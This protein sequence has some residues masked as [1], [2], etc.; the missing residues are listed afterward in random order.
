MATTSLQEMKSGR[1]V[2]QCVVLATLENPEMAWEESLAE[3]EELADTAGARVVDVVSQRREQPDPRTYLGKGKTEE[4]KRVVEAGEATLVIFDGELS[5][6]QQRNLEKVLD[7]QVL[8]RTGL[9]LDIFAQRANTAEGKLQV[10][11][12]QLEYLLPRLTNMWSHLSRIRGG[13]GLRGPG[14][15]Q[16]E[17]DRRRVRER[18]GVLKHKVEDLRQWR[19]AQ[20]SQRAQAQIPLISLV[21]YTNAGKSTLLNALSQADIFVEDKL[22][23]T[24]DPTTR[25]VHFPNG[26]RALVSDTVGFIRNLPTQLVN[27]FRATLE[28]VLSAEILV[29]VVDASN[30]AWVEQE[31]TVN[32]VLTELGAADKPTVIAF[33]KMDRVDDPVVL[34]HLAHRYPHVV[35]LTARESRGIDKL[36]EVL[37]T[38]LRSGWQDIAILLPL[39]AGDLVAELHAR[40]EVTEEDYREN[41]VY[42][43]GR[44]PA[45]LAARINY[46]GKRVQS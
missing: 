25:D 33:N 17:V 2:H 31:D 29:H 38:V 39:S 37:L 19:T 27:A 46:R 41:G 11:L 35:F 5:P 8:D 26:M 16:L 6:S 43:T 21:G 40:G 36:E 20:R 22:F 32:Q 13:I 10:E 44:A 4:L 18:I 3:L 7:V 15:T 24:L 12:A 23:A 14:E 9:I 42:L 28:E 45:D 1:P 34:H 30:P